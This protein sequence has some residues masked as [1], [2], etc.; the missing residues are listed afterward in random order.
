MIFP[1]K[2]KD[3]Y[4]LG[5]GHLPCCPFTGHNASCRTTDC[6]MFEVCYD[7]INGYYGLTQGKTSIHCA[8]V[9]SV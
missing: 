7:G 9:P 4:N 1:F 8:R 6:A 3:G 5:A 2:D